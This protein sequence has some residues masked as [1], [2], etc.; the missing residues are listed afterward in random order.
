MADPVKTLLSSDRLANR[1]FRQL[2][3]LERVADSRT[4]SVFFHGLG[5]DATDYQEYLELHD[6]HAVAV[7]LAGYAPRAT[8]H[9]PPVPVNRH[10]EMVA[11]LVER[12]GRQ[13][14][15]K[16]ILLV[17]F[18]L[19][20]DLVL[21][22]AEH[23]TGALAH[24][25]PDLAGALLLDPNV[26]RS[27]MTISRLFAAADH[28]DPLPALKKLVDLAPDLDG[29]RTLCS[30]A[31]RIA[32]KDF[33]QVHQLADDMMSYWDAAGYDQFGAR[34]SAVAKMAGKVNIVLSADYEEHLPEM[35]AAARRHG[36]TTDQVHF[37]ITELDHF[38]LIGQTV[39]SRELESLGR[40]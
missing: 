32:S 21:Q 24:R 36:C 17:G 16:R 39:L 40:G 30:Y 15:G 28:R 34:V 31:S 2:T 20:A 19:G 25:Q 1:H 38:G 37:N 11:E 10:V 33:G 9:L 18:S 26:N 12:I 8:G 5:L 23:W 6:T 7:N 35:R 29:F 4:L 3:Y 13:N 22:L 14:P 27:T